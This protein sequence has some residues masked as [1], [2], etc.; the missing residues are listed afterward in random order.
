VRERHK[1]S[2]HINIRQLSPKYL[3]ALS[4][5]R[6]NIQFHLACTPIH[7]PLHQPTY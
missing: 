4:L 3:E 5:A 6:F 7:L 2:Q 1:E